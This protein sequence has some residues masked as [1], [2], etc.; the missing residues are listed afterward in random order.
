[1][2]RKLRPIVPRSDIVPVDDK[3]LSRVLA[4][5]LA[6]RQEP[7]PV[8]GDGALAE[9][10]PPAVA[11]RALNIRKLFMERNERDPNG[12]ERVIGQ[13]NL[14][15]INFLDRGRRAAN[16]VCRIVI[17]SDE[18]EAYG[19]GF[20]VGPRLLLTNNHV[21]QSIDQAGECRAQFG[22]EV[23]AEG[24]P[25]EP[26]SFSLKPDE[27]FY[28]STELD[29][30][31]VAVARRSD[32]GVPL[33]RFGWLTL[34]PIS[35]K[36]VDG[37]AVSII[38]HP[39]GQRKQIAIHSSEVIVLPSAQAGNQAGQMI[40]Y[41]T[42]T[43]PGSSGSPVFNDQWQVFALHHKAVP[44]PDDLD[45]P[46]GQEIR[47][48]ANE[49][50][51]VSAIFDHLERRRF[52]SAGARRVLDRLARAIGLPPLPMDDEHPGVGRDNAPLTEGQSKAFPVSRWEEPKLGYDPEFHQVN[53]Q[54]VSIPLA[55]IYENLI[56]PVEPHYPKVAPLLDGSGH[57]LK[58]LHFSAVINARRRFPLMTVVNI[59]GDKLI[60]PGE[61]KDTWRQDKRIDPEYQPDDKFYSRSKTLPPEKVYFSRGHLVRLLDPCWGE[62]KEDAVRAMED[63]FHF[64]NAAPQQQSYNDIDWGNLE[65]YL[66][67]KAQATER[68]LTIFTGPI[69]RRDDP[70]YGHKREG[71]PWQIPL[72]FWKIA[73]LQKTD[74]TLAAAAFVIGQ[75]EYI[76]ALYEARVFT[77]LKP[78]STDDLR[79]RKIQTT[80]AAVEGLTRLDFSAIRQYDSARGLE[81]TQKTRWFEG[82]DDIWI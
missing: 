71:G 54:P 45:A 56:N 29:F 4:Q 43:E 53:G 51:R 31:L 18:G 25:S 2:I 66:L 32:G 41:S 67:D 63:T 78:Y 5:E 73:L 76:R 36:V 49:G 3:N 81:T 50:V 75:T 61:R 52:E 44:H 27:A 7:A 58:Y 42:D 11:A 10:V 46:A 60:H 68:K 33:E 77:G 17:Q 39:G 40:H 14:L 35:G 16:S 79:S 59:H 47:W 82:P 30:T 9:S 55:P 38:Q 22:Y 1:M 13:S 80:I 65:D 12:F 15:S 21:I 8:A 34:L 23:D 70:T 37:E 48:L 19:T 62:S 74:D 26:V 28:T 24:V 20:L 69:F 72:S 64:T 57:E 6:R